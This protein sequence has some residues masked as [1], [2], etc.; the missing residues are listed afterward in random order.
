MRLL[1]LG[2]P[3]VHFRSH[4]LRRGGATFLLRRTGQVELVMVI[5]RW[6]S[7]QTTRLYLRLGQASAARIENETSERTANLVAALVAESHVLLFGLQ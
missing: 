4:S 1:R 5:G 7:I 6:A 3:L 2:L